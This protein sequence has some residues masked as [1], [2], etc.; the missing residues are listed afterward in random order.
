MRTKSLLLVATVAGGIVL[1]LSLQAGSAETPY[2]T[3][4]GPLEGQRYETLRGLAH[5]LDE[6]ARSALED[7]IEDVQHGASSEA[8]FLA[9]IRSF[10]RGADDFHRTMDEYPTLPSEVPAQ[11]EDLTTRAHQVS[12]RIRSA[13]ALESTYENWN[14]I[15]DVLERM[16]LLLAGRDVEVPAP[17]VVAALSGSRL[18]EFRQLADDVDRNATRAHERARREVGDYPQRGQQFLGE[19]HY[20]AAQSRGLHSRADAR[21]VNPQQIG[22]AVNLLLEDARQ[23]DR[24]MRDAR[25]FTSVWD[26]SGRTITMLRRMASLV[27][28][29]G[30]CDRSLSP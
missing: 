25:V 12:D 4:A 10:A 19:L 18:Q 21:Q 27:R 24:S 1:G 23:A 8:R 15:L 11:V 20:F 13:R 22:T 2:G 3:P 5:H 14:A 26:D 6:T 28:S 17:H 29:C 9:S 7:A 16:R 30:A